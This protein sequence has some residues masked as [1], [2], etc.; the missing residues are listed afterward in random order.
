[1][2]RNISPTEEVASQ[3]VWLD[4][5]VKTQW[6]SGGL[7][8]DNIVN[9]DIFYN[10]DKLFSF[11]FLLAFVIGERGCGKTFNAKV[12]VL[13][14]YLKTGEQFIYLRRYKT[15]LDTALATFWND[16]Q[17]NGYFEDH[18]LSVSRS[19]MLTK[20]ICDE[21]VCGY[22]V[23]LSTANILKSTAFPKVKTIIFDEFILDGASGTYRYLKNEVTMMLDVIE[24]VG[25]LRDI[26]VIFLGNALSIVNPYFAYFGLDLPYKG[27]FRTFKDGAIVVNYI[28]NLKYREAKKKSKFGKL[29]EGTDYGRYAIDNEMLRDNNHFIEKKP[30][31]AVFYGVLVVNGN[32]VGI[33]Y[34]KNGYMYL[35]D[36][37][38]PNTNYRFACD[39]NDHTESTMFLNARENYYLRLCVRAYKQGLLKFESQKIKGNILPL[40]NKCVSF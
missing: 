2:T 15:E 9:N 36:K 10:Y 22:A 7:M 3:L 16:L 35:S 39:F 33:W 4:T 8:K 21:K 34:S 28:K 27:E 25:R 38:D 37:Y 13:K 14:K 31:D 23:P 26:Q 1:M 30:P 20:F 5:S 11:N 29:I 19:K 17:E 6:L 32:T 12:A 18:A 24:T 40:L